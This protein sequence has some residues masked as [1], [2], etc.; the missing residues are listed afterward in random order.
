[1]IGLALIVHAV[2]IVIGVLVLV[3]D[4]KIRNNNKLSLFMGVNVLFTF[5]YGII[6]ITLISNNFFIGETDFYL[7]YTVDLKNDPFLFSSILILI[8]YVSMLLGYYLLRPYVKS[9]YHYE[10][11]NNIL[12]IFGIILLL[13][14]LF[15]VFY[16]MASLGGVFNSLRYIQSLRYGEVEIATS[17]FLILPLSLASFVIFFSLFIQRLKFFTFN[18][19]FLVIAFL[20]SIYYVL[21]FGGRLPLTLFVLLLPMYY[22]DNNQKWSLKN[23]LILTIIGILMLNYLESL[24]NQLSNENYLAVSVIDNI[25]RLV[26]QFSFPYINTLKVH[27]FTYSNGD[28]RYFIDLISW[29]INYIPANFSNLIGLDQIKPSY[30]VNTANHHMADPNNPVAGGIP[31][32]IITFGYYQFA[33]PGTIIVTFIFGIMVS[34]LDRIFLNSDKN[35]FISLAKIRVFQIITFYPMYA[36]IE[37]FMRRRIDVVVLLIII[38]LFSKKISNKKKGYKIIATSN[39]N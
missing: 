4:Y 36:D 3:Y 33:V 20:V 9:N 8:G 35:I 32:D 14:S 21:I 1:L 30:S 34:W 7:I 18:F 31:T 12:Q 29:V 23:I 2:I 13:L 26:A 28:F 24:F 37:A 11:S 25:P 17:M 10:V 38:L 16:I 39:K 22:L 6:P 15:S 5:I 27:Q 19:L